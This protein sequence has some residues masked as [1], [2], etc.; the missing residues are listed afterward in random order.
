MGMPDLQDEIF[1]YAKTFINANS[2]YSPYV[3][4][5]FLKYKTNFQ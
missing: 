5:A 4:K 2:T 3:V 1:L